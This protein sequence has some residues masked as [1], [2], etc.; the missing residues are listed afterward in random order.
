MDITVE[1]KQGTAWGSIV[2]GH[3]MREEEFFVS[4]QVCMEQVVWASLG[5]SLE[6]RSLRPYPRPMELESKIL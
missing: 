2:K 4:Q 1:S 6:I 3:K 5:S